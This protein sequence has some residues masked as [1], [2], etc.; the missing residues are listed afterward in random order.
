MV[1]YPATS[2]LQKQNIMNNYYGLEEDSLTC[3]PPQY[4]NSEGFVDIPI[5]L[6]D[7]GSLSCAWPNLEKS[8]GCMFSNGDPCCLPPT[9]YGFPNPSLDKS[10]QEW[11]WSTYAG[12]CSTEGPQCL[13]GYPCPIQGTPEPVTVKKYSP[14]PPGYV[15]DENVETKAG[16]CGVA[17]TPNPRTSPGTSPCADMCHRYSTCGCSA[18]CGDCSCTPYSGECTPCCVKATTGPPYTCDASGLCTGYTAPPT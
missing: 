13:P 11:G 14:C 17:P 9:K 2:A 7:N 15:W 3:I 10:A 12:F 1:C 6:P 4:C 16:L 5:G 18:T 8:D